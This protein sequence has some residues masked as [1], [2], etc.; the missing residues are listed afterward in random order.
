MI[1]PFTIVT[2][3]S[4]YAT[5]QKVG[6][7]IADW[8]YGK[9]IGHLQNGVEHCSNGIEKH[10]T[11]FLD[12]AISE[13]DYVNESDDRL[14]VVAFSYLYRAICYT[15]LLK[16]PLAYF[17]LDKLESIEYDF[18]TLKKDT[19]EETKRDGRSCRAD[20]ER[21]E[22]AYNEYL[23]SLNSNE[24][25]KSRRQDVQNLWKKAFVV[26]S[27][28]LIVVVLAVVVFFVFFE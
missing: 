14:F 11:V 10:D 22:N 8:S 25:G 2:I 9:N 19:I 26:L 13:L 1:D 20:V 23:R 28:V 16:F 24:E 3:L 6:G 17:Y 18:F 21:L 27:C 15:Y 5:G 12:K 7:L 4:S